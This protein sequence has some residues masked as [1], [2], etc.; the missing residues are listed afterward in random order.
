M[1]HELLKMIEYKNKLLRKAKRSDRVRDWV[2]AR[3][4]RDRSTLDCREAKR[5]YLTSSAEKN[6]KNSKNVLAEHKSCNS[7]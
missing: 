6:L 4:Y 7:W 5:D 3:V 2:K 1:T